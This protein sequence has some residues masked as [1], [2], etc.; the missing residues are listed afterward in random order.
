M[1]SSLQYFDDVSID[2]NCC[3]QSVHEKNYQFYNGNSVPRHRITRNVLRQQV[4]ADHRR[5]AVKSESLYI[6]YSSTLAFAEIAVS[7]A[8]ND[9]I[10]VL[11]NLIHD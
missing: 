8:I 11:T 3:F 2:A 9:A 1:E 7:D 10:S 4:T 6:L 5:Y